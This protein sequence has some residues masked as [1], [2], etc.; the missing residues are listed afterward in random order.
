MYSSKYKK[1]ICIKEPNFQGR[2][3]SDIIL[4]LNVERLYTNKSFSRYK[5]CIKCSHA[6]CI[7]CYKRHCHWLRIFH[8]T[9]SNHQSL[10]GHRN[11]RKIKV[12]LVCLFTNSKSVYNVI[13]FQTI[14]NHVTQIHYLVQQNFCQML[15]PD[16][17]F[18]T[19]KVSAFSLQSSL[20]MNSRLNTILGHSIKLTHFQ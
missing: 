6:N 20:S 4:K 8:A 11:E 12:E 17:N 9:S 10:Q 5:S 13:F 14:S 3:F 19:E 1:N 18:H 2:N 15:N 7:W 16:Y